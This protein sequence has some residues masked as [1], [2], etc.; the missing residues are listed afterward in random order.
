MSINGLVLRGM[1]LFVAFGALTSGAFASADRSP[2]PG[3]VYRLKPGVYVAKGT[4]CGNAPNVAIRRYDGVGISDPHTH[5]CRANILSQ[6]GSSFVVSQSCVDAGVGSAPRAVE[7]QTVDVHDALT[8]SLATK[9]PKIGYR[10]CPSYM[11]PKG[12]H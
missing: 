1:A 11:L 8:F 7:R 12:V 2:P 4:A 5:A 3:G 10:Y 6:R 9:G